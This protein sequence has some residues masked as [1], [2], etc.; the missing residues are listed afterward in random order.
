MI[1]NFLLPVHRDK[2]QY[3]QCEIPTSTDSFRACF[4][5]TILLI[6]L[7]LILINYI[8]THNTNTIIYVSVGGFKR[9]YQILCAFKLGNWKYLGPGSLSL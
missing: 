8:I 6:L 2:L 5:L 1:Y 3:S 9:N 4:A 7:A